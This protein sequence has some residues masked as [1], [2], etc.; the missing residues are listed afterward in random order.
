MFNTRFDY[1]ICEYMVCCRSRQLRPKTMNSY[2]QGLPKGGSPQRRALLGG[3]LGRGIRAPRIFSGLARERRDEGIPP[4][5]DE[6]PVLS[7]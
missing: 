6:I 7:S 2:E 3:T 1:L 5:A 4:Y